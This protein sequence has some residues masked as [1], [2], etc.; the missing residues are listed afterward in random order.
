[1][2]D[3]SI[4]VNVF[5]SFQ[6]NSPGV[7]GIAYVGAVCASSIGFRSG[8]VEWFVSDLQTGQ[9]K[10]FPFSKAFFQFIKNEL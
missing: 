4:N 6:N 9:V 8:I 1:M 7:V 2:T 10:L 5:M 3:D